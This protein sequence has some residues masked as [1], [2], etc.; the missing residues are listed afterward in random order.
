MVAW[1]YHILYIARDALDSTVITRLRGLRGCY[2][3]TLQISSPHPPSLLRMPQ[4][5]HHTDDKRQ[6]ILASAVEVDP[7]QSES[8]KSD[9]HLSDSAERTS[10]SF[11]SAMSLVSTRE[12]DRQILFSSWTAI[13]GSTADLARNPRGIS[14]TRII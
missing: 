5:L 10:I 7:T 1:V 6:H 8:G 14:V 9:V 13:L 11:E 12:R 4:A 2:K 3:D